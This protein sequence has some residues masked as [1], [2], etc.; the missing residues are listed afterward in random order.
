MAV[1][2]GRN[3][4]SPTLGLTIGLVVT[5]AAVV[6]Y[7]AYTGRQIVTLRALQNDLIDRDRKD[8]L[9]LLRIQNDLNSLALAM[10]DMLDNDEPYPLA[11]WS[12][13]FERI[14]TDLDD[15]LRKEE[16]VSPHDRAPEQRTYLSNSLAQFWDAVG[17]TFALAGAGKEQEARAQIRITLQARQAALST[18][19][20]RLLV[21]NNESEQQATA[22]IAGIYNRVEHQIYWFLGVTLIAILLTGLYVIRSNRILFA[23]V[24]AL[25]EQRSELARQLISTQ[26]STLRYLS[27]EL[28][29]EFGQ[30]LTAIGSMLTRAGKQIPENSNLRAELQEVRDIAQSTL[31][32]VRTLSQALHPVMLEEAG[33]EHT[34]EWYFPNFER[35]TGIKISYEKSPIT[36]DGNGAIHIYRV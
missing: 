14:H 8:S 28:H 3:E 33:L 9:Q 32:K 25:S 31:E 7:S 35:Q 21:E 23:R 29:D 27:R 2:V 15:A 24:A 16:Q 6:L 11:A 36:I 10:R 30:V 12:S 18:A 26:E 4:R 13:Q 34:L 22:R 19:V 17:R 5:L 1:G 20:A